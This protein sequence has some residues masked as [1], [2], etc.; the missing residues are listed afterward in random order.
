MSQCVGIIPVSLRMIKH[1]CFR[2][3]KT[4][5]FHSSLFTCFNNLFFVTSGINKMA[6]IR[7]LLLL[8]ESVVAWAGIT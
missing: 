3:K 1:V 5:P 4:G 7:T 6:E 2:G 8:R